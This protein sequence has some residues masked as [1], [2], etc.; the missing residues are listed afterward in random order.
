MPA[1]RTGKGSGDPLGGV[2]IPERRDRTLLGF[3][4]QNFLTSS[5][6]RGMLR[7]TSVLVPIVAVTGRSVFSHT[8]DKEYQDKL[9]L[10]GFLLNQ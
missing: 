8:V 2:T 3:S 6:I 7:P 10:P 1:L 5:R 4:L 9:F